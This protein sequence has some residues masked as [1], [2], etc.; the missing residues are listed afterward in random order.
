MQSTVEYMKGICITYTRV[1]MA[2]PS[3]GIGPPTMMV[4]AQPVSLWIS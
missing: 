4:Q 3:F 1:W 2:P